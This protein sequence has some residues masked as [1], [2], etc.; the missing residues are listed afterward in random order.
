MHKAASRTAEEE[1]EQSNSPKETH[2]RRTRKGEQQEPI[3]ADK[4]HNLTSHH[5]EKVVEEESS[6]QNKRRRIPKRRWS[7]SSAASSA[8]S[9]MQTEDTDISDQQ[10]VVAVAEPKSYKAK[11]QP[12]AFSDKSIPSGEEKGQLEKKCDDKPLPTPGVNCNGEGEKESKGLIGFSAPAS[13]KQT[14]SRPWK[15]QQQQQKKSNNPKQTVHQEGN[16]ADE[17]AANQTLS[18]LLPFAQEEEAESLPAVHQPAIIPN[19]VDVER[20][21]AKIRRGQPL[22]HKNLKEENGVVVVGKLPKPK[23]DHQIVKKKMRSCYVKLDQAL[24]EALSQK[25][26]SDEAKGEKTCV[27][28]RRKT[29]PIDNEKTNKRI[30]A[31]PSGIGES[32]LGSRTKNNNNNFSCMQDQQQLKQ[33]EEEEGDQNGSNN[34]NNMQNHEDTQLMYGKKTTTALQCSSTASSGSNTSS[35]NK[36]HFTAELVS[37][38]GCPT[39]KK[40]VLA[41][42]VNDEADLFLPEPALLALPDIKP[43]LPLHQPLSLAE[44]E[45][46]VEQE[47]SQS[48]NMWFEVEDALLADAQRTEQQQ[49][50]KCLTGLSSKQEPTVDSSEEDDDEVIFVCSVDGDYND[51]FSVNT[52]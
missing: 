11:K 47:H 14:R 33:E 36:R 42:V 28:T 20:H 24:G 34:T 41:P 9:S 46:S 27:L 32:Y 3:G 8:S 18:H 37:S 2:Q 19:V 40:V 15:K 21:S 4:R 6:R 43:H 7:L 48:P 22:K 5:Q 35:I 39:S 52:N 1:K 30:G 23:N 51:T 50:Q 25:P 10:K 31:H 26:S 12:S 44:I 45:V 16:H 13:A 38:Q 49:Q 29:C 17:S